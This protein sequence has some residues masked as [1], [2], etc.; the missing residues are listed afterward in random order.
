MK[1]LTLTLCA[2][3]TMYA[4]IHTNNNARRHP[5]MRQ[6][7]QSSMHAAIHTVIHAHKYV[8]NHVYD[9]ATW[10]EVY[11]NKAN[12]RQLMHYCLMVKVYLIFFLMRPH[13]DF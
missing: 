8:Y 4:V 6:Y 2:H 12:M 10:M 9:M 13:I 5:Y 3:A 7:T 1:L 11:V